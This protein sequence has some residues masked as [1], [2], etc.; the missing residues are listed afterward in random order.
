MKYTSP[1]PR[2]A[3]I[4]F[5][6]EDETP[7]SLQFSAGLT[8]IHGRSDTGKTYLA[9]SIDYIFSASSKPF[10]EETGYSDIIADLS[11][12]AGRLSIN[13]PLV[14]SK[15]L[16]AAD[17]PKITN[18]TYG[19]TSSETSVEPSLS[20][21]LL[22]LIGINEPRRILTSAYA[23]PGRL[24]WRKFA[25]IF[26]LSETEVFTKSS[27]LRP[28]STETL[29]SV[30]L[31]LFDERFEH[32]RKKEDATDQQK[33]QQHMSDYIGTKIDK[34][35]TTIADISAEM[36]EFSGRDMEGELASALA[37]DQ[38]VRNIISDLRRR[39]TELTS[40]QVT[41]SKQLAI[42]SETARRYQMLETKYLA[43]IKRLGLILDAQH[44]HQDT[45]APD[46]CPF[47]N[48]ELPEQ[49]HEDYRQ[50]VQ[51][52][53][54]TTVNQLNGLREAL[55]DLN[56]QV[57]SLQSENAQIESTV[58]DIQEQITHTHMPKANQAQEVIRS[59]SRYQIA[60]R[61]K[62]AYTELHSEWTNDLHDITHELP[63]TGDFNPR[64]LFPAKFFTAM[65]Q[66]C[67]EILAHC[68]YPSMHTVDFNEEDFDIRINGKKKSSHGKG[69]RAFL[70]TVVLMALRKYIHEHAVHKPF[71]YLIDTPTLG[72]DSQPDA[73]GLVT[74][75]NEEGRPTEGLQTRLFQYFLD[76]Q[77]QGQIIIVDNTKDTPVLDYTQDGAKEYAFT[78][79]PSK[80]NSPRTTIRYGLLP[81]LEPE[82][83]V[84]EP[85]RFETTD[86]LPGLDEESK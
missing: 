32:Y 39:A 45:N 31:L 21:V 26:Y 72:L 64:A 41:I 85:N 68:K 38:E 4:T 25:K 70:N 55:E 24:T 76:T 33:R 40:R 75:R 44:A 48:G 28:K 47:C 29:S 60:L 61:K 3:R 69:Y 34:M 54:S 36:D 57:D 63:S 27:I 14:G 71:L 19:L 58:R 30:A 46:N 62:E 59:Y 66:Y 74:E 7:S 9:D 11:T 83:T 37:I 1:E 79:M 80:D 5:K 65:T 78:A 49:V 2:L 73:L 67:Q 50:T 10:D 13:R 56:T 82:T 51:G 43:R 53:M 42:Q 35:V 22:S 12:P 15:A 81:G 20:D 52:E 6:G 18:G 84:S 17:D 86:P 77:N 16:I 23:N 8:L